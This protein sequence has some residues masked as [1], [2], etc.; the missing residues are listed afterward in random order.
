MKPLFDQIE[1]E[2][3]NLESDFASIFERH[4]AETIFVVSGHVYE[5][6][7]LPGIFSKLGVNVIRFGGYTPNPK[8]EE[9]C[10]GVRLL[11]DSGASMI[12]AVGGGSCMDTAKCI[13]MYAALDQ[14]MDYMQQ[15]MVSSDI[16]LVA[17]PTTAGTG[18]DGNGNI[19]IYRDGV[20][21]SLHHES[22]VPEYVL[23]DP[24]CLKGMSDYQKRATL[25]DAIAQC[26]ESLW[27]KGCSEKSASYAE[28][29]LQ[30]LAENYK[31]YLEG[32][33]KVSPLMQRAAY[34]SGRAINISKTTAAHALSYKLSAVCSVP[35]GHAV[36]LLLG[37]VCKSIEAYLQ[38]E[39]I[40]NID[41]ANTGDDDMDHLASK[42]RR[43]MNI[44]VPG[45]SRTGALSPAIEQMGKTIGLPIPSYP[46]E[47]VIEDMAEQVNP[48]RL[49]NNPIGYTKDQIVS[50][51]E[52]AFG[53]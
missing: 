26:I 9:I 49:G 13:K 42:I 32:D 18:S 27:A 40:A 16:P 38:K 7:G 31:R 33:S 8:Y 52:E 53:R 37:P 3:E 35:H 10:E 46:G 22:A 4:E 29:G 43:I 21:K 19:V 6:T 36:W 28:E 23:F 44:I 50:L 17:V 41:E 2:R 12:V 47:R 48:E 51:Y 39:G 20:K 1:I 25:A 34:L 14:N 11:I 45:E 15:Q 5:E 30:V 24:D